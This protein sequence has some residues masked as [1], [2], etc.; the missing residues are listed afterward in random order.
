MSKAEEAVPVKKTEPALPKTENPW[1]S[2]IELRRDM[3]RMFDDL[4]GRFLSTPLFTKG[5]F[6]PFKWFTE[7]SGKVTPAMD[8]VEKDK[9]FQITAEMPGMSEKD[10]DVTVSNGVLTIKGEKRE[11]KEEKKKDYFLSERRYG[12]F[13]RSWR[14]PETVDADKIEAKFAKGVLS[15]TLPKRPET[16]ATAKKIAIAAE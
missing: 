3:D 1:Q 16:E 11:E 2:L 7:K 10:V 15:I 4:S 9:E 6:E 12:S 8:V 5:D 14:L 13:N